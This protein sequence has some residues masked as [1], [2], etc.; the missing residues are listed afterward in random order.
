LKL[1]LYDVGGESPLRRVLSAQGAM[2]ELLLAWLAE[3]MAEPLSE[4]ISFVGRQR[5]AIPRSIT[6]TP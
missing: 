2:H 5:Q 3:P 4:R 6:S 1:L